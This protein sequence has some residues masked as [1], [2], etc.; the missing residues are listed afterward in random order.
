MPQSPSDA[1]ETTPL[2]LHALLGIE[3][4]SA[5]DPFVL[6]LAGR[7]D[8]LN[9]RGVLHGGVISALLDAALGGAIVR[10]I[11]PQEWCGTTQLSVQFLRPAFDGPFEAEGEMTHRGRRCAFA[12]GT[13]RDRHGVVVARAHGTW[14]IWPRRPRR[15]VETGGDLA[16]GSSG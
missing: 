6:R 3:V 1:G 9:Q 4:A 12:S 14:H 8:L 13:V 10:G 11:A 2:P 7:P 16:P 5:Q 15:P